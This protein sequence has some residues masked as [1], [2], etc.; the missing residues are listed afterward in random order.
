MRSMSTISNHGNLHQLELISIPTNFQ[1]DETLPNEFSSAEEGEI[2]DDVSFTCEKVSNSVS[3]TNEGLTD[4]G[5]FVIQDTSNTMWNNSEARHKVQDKSGHLTKAI[6]SIYECDEFEDGNLVTSK[7]CKDNAKDKILVS[8][9]KDHFVNEIRSNNDQDKQEISTNYSNASSSFK[10]VD[11]TDRRKENVNSSEDKT[12]HKKIATHVKTNQT[13]ETIS[14]RKSREKSK[15]KIMNPE[16][17]DSKIKEKIEKGIKERYGTKD[18]I[19]SHTSSREARHSRYRRSR[20][21]SFRSTSKENDKTRSKNKSPTEKKR[22]KC[23]SRSN[24]TETRR[25]GY[26]DDDYN[27]QQS[28]LFYICHLLQ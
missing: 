17:S 5:I 25:K 21:S 28:Y 11:T 18:I 8:N 23:E 10:N 6:L 12:S 4:S 22:E 16:N 15:E 27:T 9:D 13:S 26:E 1:I 14:K 7:R 24:S 3:C 20:S 19:P 2:F